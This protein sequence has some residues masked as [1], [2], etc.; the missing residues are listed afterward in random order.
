MAGSRCQANFSVDIFLQAARIADH[1]A[2][3]T[4]C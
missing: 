3:P 4:W 2:D 1:G